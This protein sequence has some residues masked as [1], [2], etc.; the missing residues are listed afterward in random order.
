LPKL[1]AAEKSNIILITAIIAAGTQIIG[2]LTL[3]ALYAEIGLALAFVLSNV[4]GLIF[5]FTI[6]KFFL[7]FD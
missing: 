2:I 7:K 1:W 4:V 3:G 6:T 5:T